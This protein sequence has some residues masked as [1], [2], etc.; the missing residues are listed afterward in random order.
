MNFGSS[1][2]AHLEW[3]GSVFVQFIGLCITWLQAWFHVLIEGTQCFQCS[4][5]VADLALNSNP[6]NHIFVL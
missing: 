6:K 3:N 1:R 2:T 5:G 4:K